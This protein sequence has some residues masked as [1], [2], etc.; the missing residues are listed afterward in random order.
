MKNIVQ[1]KPFSEI[2]RFIDDSLFPAFPKIGLD[3]AIDL[4]EEKGNVIAKMNLPGVDAQELDIVIDGDVLTITGSRQEEHETDEK[5]YYSKEIRRG[6]FSRSVSL[7]SSVEAAK[8]E[9]SYKD[10]VLKVTMPSIPGQKEKAVK[11][12]V[13]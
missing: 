12:K 13:K 5:D 9:A 7:P 8:S 3:L 4:Y 6:S 10:G 11:V 2:D 1:W